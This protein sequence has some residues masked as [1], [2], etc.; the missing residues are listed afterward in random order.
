[1]ALRNY[2]YAKHCEDKLHHTQKQPHDLANMADRN[3]EP[4]SINPNITETAKVE[5]NTP[6]K[7][8]C[9]D[10]ENCNSCQNC[11]KNNKVLPKVSVEIAKPESLNEIDFTHY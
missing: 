4:S 7:E 5:V 6:K 1:M 10:I 2:L 3:P 11:P 9:G 8:G